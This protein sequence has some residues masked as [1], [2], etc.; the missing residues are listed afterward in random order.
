MILAIDVGNTQIVVA[1]FDGDELKNSWRISTDKNKSS[2]ELGMVMM[3]MLQFSSISKEDIEDVIISSVVPPVMHS[4]TNAIK[5]YIGCAPLVV[6]AGIKTGLNIRYDNPREVGAD[7]IVNAVGAIHKYGTPVVIVDFGT[8]NTY[9]AINKEGEYLGGII[10]AGVKISMDA[11]FERAAKLPKVEIVKPS[12]VIGKNTV[13]A[14]QA[15]AIY[16]QAGQVDRIVKEIKKELDAPDCRVIA[17]GGF[18]SLI[19]AES[20][21]IDTVDKTLTLDGLNLIYKKN[22]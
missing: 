19:A 10:T 17:T 1:L 21:E 11:L 8:A 22:K 6:G 18:A 7:R 13:S 2:D 4:L 3:Q 5:R 16:G 20:Q 9:C 15:G 12:G 14:M